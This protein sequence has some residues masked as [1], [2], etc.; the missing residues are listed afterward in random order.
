MRCIVLVLVVFSLFSEADA[1]EDLSIPAKLR[2]E[3]APAGKCSSR[4][5]VTFTQTHVIWSSGER[6]TIRYEMDSFPGWIGSIHFRQ[7]G[8]VSFWAHDEALNV[9]T[10]FL[11]GFNMPARARWERCGS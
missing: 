5:K 11:E 3:W 6:D 8:I 1:A 9:L 7:E 10:F 4:E 2:G